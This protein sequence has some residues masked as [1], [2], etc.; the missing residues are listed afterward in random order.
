MGL[1][2]SGTEA[3]FGGL[4]APNG[5]IGGAYYGGLGLYGGLYGLYD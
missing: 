5:V 1:C 3:Y 4:F 2:F